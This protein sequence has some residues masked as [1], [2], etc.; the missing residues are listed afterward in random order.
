MTSPDAPEPSG[1]GEPPAPQYGQRVPPG[2]PI[3]LYGQPAG[4][5][6]PPAPGQPQPG[7]VPYGQP[8]YGQ[9]A[10]GGYGVPQYGAPQYGAPQ[11]GD[12]RPGYRPA[13]LPVVPKPG[14]V[15]LRP[16]TL[17]E[18]FDGA[19][20][21][22]RRNMKVMLGLTLA[23]VAVCVV[24]LTLVGAAFTPWFDARFGEVYDDLDDASS[25]V[26]LTSSTLLGPTL[27]SEVG[28]LLAGVI[29]TGILVVAISR[30]VLGLRPTAREVWDQARSRIWALLGVSL[31]SGLLCLLI[32]G[33]PIA[34]LFLGIWQ[35]SVPLSVIGGLLVLAS[36]PAVVWVSVSLGFAPAVVVLEESPVLPAMARSWRLVRSSFWRVLG[37]TL[38]A[39][40]I[41]A[42][43]QQIVGVPLGVAA[44]IV[45]AA[46]GSNVLVIVL[47]TLSS[48]IGYTVGIAFSA[49]VTSLLYIDVRMRR[50]GLDVQ[51]AAAANAPPR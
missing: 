40:I 49:T 31:L 9:P 45:S 16:L 35:E 41:V 8:P 5:P 14:V 33:V 36:I 3:P 29:A 47:T 50:E 37:I 44:G 38:L 27:G 11:Y 51:L 18:I 24:L 43:V 39:A 12:G 28:M 34:L 21:A 13:P 46:N 7:Q 30:V 20:T 17:G 22:V 23:V 2:S 32:V 25:S 48:V 42:V 6:V 10:P 15:P 4:E 19:F 26:L 1:W